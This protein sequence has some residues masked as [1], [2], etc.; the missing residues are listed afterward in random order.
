[1]EVHAYWSCMEPEQNP[2]MAIWERFVDY[3]LGHFH[4]VAD[5]M[6]VIE[7]RDAREL[8]PGGLANR[9]DF[10]NHREF[11]QKVLAEEPL[12]RDRGFDR[13]VAADDPN[14]GLISGEQLPDGHELEPG[15]DAEAEIELDGKDILDEIEA[16]LEADDAE[17]EA[18]L[19]L[20]Q[21]KELPLQR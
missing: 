18:G 6:R 2:R 11:V 5:L 9:I 13:I 1:M 19:P 10:K 8:F 12:D 17:R 7:R 20:E 4:A 16:D 15:E 21:D 14:L 3:E